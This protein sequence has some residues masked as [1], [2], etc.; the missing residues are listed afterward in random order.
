M[1]Y[2]DMRDN[3]K[4]GDIVLFSGNS[5]ISSG[6]KIVTSSVWSHVGMILKI[7]Q[8]DMVFVWEST[9]LTKLADA[10]D[11]KTKQGVQLVLLSDRV[12][13][14]DGIMSVRHLSKEVSEH[15]V[16]ELMKFRQTVKNRPYEESKIELIKSAYDGWLGDNDEDLSSLFCSEL[17]A[18][19]YQRMKLVSE[20]LP[21]NEYTPADFSAAKSKSID[22][23]NGISL[24]PEILITRSGIHNP[25]D[26]Y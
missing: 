24:G 8:Y 9:T 12:D 7:P 6:I 26:Q 4:T 23:L 1:L 21:S 2:K 11:G 14:Y 16:F 3:L 20:K 13:T 5:L 18:E 17:V 19:A 22:W 15:S 10:I 25:A